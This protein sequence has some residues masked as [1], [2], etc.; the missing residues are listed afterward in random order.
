[1]LTMAHTQEH[2]NSLST[3]SSASKRDQA[4]DKLRRLLILQQIPGGQRLREAE[5]ADRLN[6]NRSALREAFARLAAEGLIELGPKTGY[7]VPTL[8][9][10]DIREVTAVRIALEAAAIDILCEN[11]LNT[12]Q[13]LQSMREACDL[14]GQ[15]VDRDYHLS[16]V[17]ADRRF[18]DELIQATHNQRLAIAYRHAP[19]PI[20]HPDVLA[21]HEWSNN[22]RRTHM[23][24][25]QILYDILQGHAHA[26]K[27]VLRDH[28]T[29]HMHGVHPKH[30][31]PSA[32]STK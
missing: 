13:H 1:M 14:L 6:V 17:E 10:E 20:L 32:E 23:E 29:G 30:Q 19:L 22:V 31:P 5:W 8:S 26:A 18:H 24:H 4:Y 11:G 28:L 15:M 9:P 12:L 2:N 7:F 21:G 16:V 27:E 25:Q 3:S